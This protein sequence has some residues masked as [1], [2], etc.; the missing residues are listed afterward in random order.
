MKALAISATS[1][2]L[3]LS[4]SSSSPPPQQRTSVL[5]AI[6]TETPQAAGTMMKTFETPDGFKLS[7]GEYWPYV[8]TADA[9]YP[10]D[11]MWGFYPKK[12][13][14]PPGET[15]P[16]PDTASKAAVA[17]A[18]RAYGELQKFLAA[19]ANRPKDFDLVVEEGKD[20]GVTRLFYLWTN[21]YTKAADPFPPGVRPARLWYWKRKTPDPKRPAGY[22]KWESTLTQKGECKTPNLDEAATYL[23]EKR[24][25]LAKNKTTATQ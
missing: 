1:A 10:E 6:T 21:D 2:L 24:E 9:R 22:W 3:L 5:K 18:E 23:R 7:G 15:D 14:M 19:P 25:E 17:C 4:C 16:N 12:G 11:V 8:G 13:E 20:Q